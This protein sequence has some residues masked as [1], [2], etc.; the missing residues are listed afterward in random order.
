MTCHL[1]GNRSQHTI[2]GI[3]TT[4]C[5]ACSLLLP[6]AES[7]EEQ[8]P[9]QAN[10][11][12]D[13][14]LLLQPTAE[15][16]VAMYPPE[17]VTTTSKAGS[18]QHGIRLD[19]ADTVKVRLP[20]SMELGS[21][22][23]IEVRIRL[24]SM[25]QTNYARIIAAE[26]FNPRGGFAL[27]LRRDGR[28]AFWASSK[29]WITSDIVLKPDQWHLVGVMCRNNR[30]FLFRGQATSRPFDFQSQPCRPAPG[31]VEIG[32]GL[33]A[34]LAGVR[35]SRKA[36]YWNNVTPGKN[37]EWEL[38]AAYTRDNGLRGQV[39]LNGYWGR[40]ST[41]DQAGEYVKARVPAIG[42]TKKTWEYY[43]EFTLPETWTRRRLELEVDCFSTD[44]V[45]RLNGR[46]VGRVARKKRYITIPV[47]ANL[48]NDQPCRLRI[49]TGLIHGDVTLK[50]YPRSRAG[51]DESYIMTSWRRREVR[52]R[53][54]GK[55]RPGR[56]LEARFAVYRDPKLSRKVPGLSAK[57]TVE[58]DRR[59]HWATEITLPW[60]NPR[61]WSQW[62]PALYYYTAELRT[63]AGDPVDRLL[64]RRFG[65]REV[66]IEN[67]RF[68]MNG[69][70]VTI[71][72]SVWEGTVGYQNG[73]REQ[74]EYMLRNL[75]KMGITGGFRVRHDMVFNVADEVG[76]L[77]QANAGSM[78]KLN[79]WDPKSG[80]TAMTGNE[81][82]DDISRI[83]RRWREH[84]SIIIWQSNT[85]YGLAG[86]HPEYAGQ[87]YDPSFFFPAN[88]NIARAQQ[89]QTIFRRMR[90]LVRDL[91]PCREVGTGSSP[92][93]RVD[94]LTRYLCANLDLQEREEFFD[95]WLRSNRPKAI[96]VHEF[97]VPFQGH[98]F[99]RRIDHQMPHTGLWPKIHLEVAASLF[100]GQAF[101]WEPRERIARWGSMRYDE[102]AQTG[103]MQKCVAEQGYHVWRAWRT[104]GVNLSGHHIIPAHGFLHHGSTSWNK[105]SLKDADDPRRPGLS[106]L[107]RRGYF[108]LLGIDKI[109]PAGKAILRALTPLMA[110]IGGPD[111]HFTSKDHLYFSGAKVRK[112][113]IVVNDLD[114]DARLSGTWQL[115]D[116]AGKT[117]R[118]GRIRGL[119]R[120]GA[121]SLTDIPL[122][123]EAPLVK[124]RSDF[125]IRLKLGS[126]LPGCLDDEFRIT[127]FPPHTRPQVKFA[128][129]IWYLNISDDTTHETRHFFINRDNQQFL[130]AAGIRARL[131]KGMRTFKYM[132]YHPGAAYDLYRGRKLVT[133]GIPQPG[134][135]LIIPRLVLRTF[136]DDRQLA[137]RTLERIRLDDLVEKGLRVIIFEQDLDNIFG[138]QTE[139]VRPRR[140]FMAADG[141]PVFAGLRQSDLSYWSG[142]SDLTHAI[143][144]MSHTERQFPDRIWHTS[145]TNSVATRTLI[146]P[147]RGACRA[148]AVSGFDLN[149]SPLLEVTRGRG[150]MLFC[151]MD[152]TNRYGKDPA[153]TILVDNIFRYMTTAAAPDPGRNGLRVVRDPARVKA[154]K[155]VFRAAM[156]KGGD[157]WGITRAEIFFRES[158]Y[159]DNWITRK[160]PD[161]PVPVFTDSANAPGGLPQ[162]IRRNRATGRFELTL[163]PELFATGWSRKKLALIRGALIVNQGGSLMQGPA[164][165]HHGRITDLYPEVWVEGFVHPYTSDIW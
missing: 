129:R 119:V 162:V 125:T 47:P 46:E 94:G 63:P 44:A 51:I 37:G 110:Y 8:Y 148:L 68:V 150:R 90:K 137:L 38:P 20:G 116:T 26:S 24:S 85:A 120:A 101:T 153:A 11:T 111:T 5:L 118:R 96:W 132:G 65:F 1:P 40:R 34:E 49:I 151:T 81:N 3:A 88:R 17:T 144:A 41:G 91:D 82:L 27:A 106:M 95:F 29:S 103:V 28:L 78:V 6:A 155:R 89:A 117:I 16:F 105:T 133:E 59:G 73:M 21:E 122:E 23:T 135:L 149:Q 145:N 87:Q 158:I 84:P 142:R 130:R 30:I 71:N 64:P 52:L 67:G 12:P 2:M 92:Y 39:T 139:D 15:G 45:I 141:H 57:V 69:I 99:L 109:L 156:P 134:D 70:P 58:P 97:G 62:H 19:T 77:L 163:Y 93:S 9:R 10:C 75:K 98:Y 114:R 74:V 123:F 128:G 104:Y 127:V 61:P 18:T 102:F 60:K 159:R 32:K 48:L 86:M 14:I 79:I 72:D 164:L 43:R 22:F 152:V 154:R 143:T 124:Q 31:R 13:T 140:V 146:R 83:V 76:M 4:L 53:L 25:P 115:L 35:I 33:A 66:W 107:V 131:V 160:L 126:N 113:V 42:R 112:A 147:Q 136:R 165:S 121:R 56:K 161:K 7:P 100:G 138:M 80:L 36:L 55:G 108:P 50:S 54:T 157:G